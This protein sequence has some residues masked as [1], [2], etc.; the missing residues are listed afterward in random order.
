MAKN[1]NDVVLTHFARTPFD[2]YGGIASGIHSIDYTEMV[3]RELIKR[4]GLKESQVEAIFHGTALHLETGMRTDIPIRQAL[5]HAGFPVSTVSVT[6]NRACCSTTS[7]AQFAWKDLTY[8]EA[9]LVFVTGADNMQNVPHYINPIIRHQAVRMG[10]IK[11]VDPLIGA[12]YPGF[13]IV[14]KDAGEVALEYG[15]TREM[16]DEWAAG[17][18]EKWGKAFDKG[19]FTEEIFPIEVPQGKKTVIMDKDQQPRPG[20]TVEAL[21]KLSTVYGSP[22]V[23]GGNAPG[24]NSGASGVVLM[25]RKKADELGLQPLAKVL[26]VTSIADDFKYI[27]RVPAKAILHACETNGLK[28]EDIE[29]IEINEAFAAMPLVSTK[30][31]SDGDAGKWDYLK[32]ITNINGGAVAIGHPIGGT[33]TRIMMT[34]MRELR[35]RGGKYCVASICGGLAQ[36]DAVILEAEY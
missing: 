10:E 11:A 24:L 20:T 18:H 34:A 31:L 30:V 5:L 8:G 29:V 22:T 26:K 35:A 9:E 14:S 19:Y 17:S 21:S 33:G 27:A 1:A 4:S 6:I 16:Q 13:G 28:L 2:R 3:L 23:T 15:I 36:G 12:G 7:A 32:S 25:T